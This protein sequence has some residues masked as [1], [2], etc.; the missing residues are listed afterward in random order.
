MK[1]GE[2]MGLWSLVDQ[3]VIDLRGNL[4]TQRLIIS[5]ENDD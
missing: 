5:W 4:K 2:K 3:E 1:L